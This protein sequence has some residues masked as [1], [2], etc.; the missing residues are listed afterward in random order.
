MISQKELDHIK[1]LAL[2]YRASKIFT[3]WDC[4][5]PDPQAWARNLQL[6]FLPIAFGGFKKGHTF[7]YM[8]RGGKH[9]FPRPTINGFPCFDQVH[10]FNKEKE[11]K[12]REILVFLDS[13]D[14]ENLDEITL[15]E[16]EKND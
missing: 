4:Y 7:F 2:D 14:Q 11:D 9:E 13:K 16:G 6:V 12:L 15:T 3:S 5:D 10:C 8:P 1:K